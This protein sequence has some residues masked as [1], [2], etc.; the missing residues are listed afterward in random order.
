[1]N[2]SLISII[3]PIYKVED[4][5]TRCV[6]SILEQ[7]YPHMEIILV[8]DGSP[9][10]CGEICDAYAKQDKR[11]S[12][13][14]QEN[15]GLSMARNNGLEKASGDYIS[16]IDSDDWIEP[17]MYETMLEYMMEH[18]LELSECIWKRKNE[19]LVKEEFDKIYIETRDE[20]LQRM[21]VPGFYNVG[22][23]IYKR[24]LIG[25]TR[26]RK[27]VLYEDGL[28]NS[29]IYKKVTQVGFI[30]RNFFNYFQENESIIRSGYSLKKL[31]GIDVTKEKVENFT[32]MTKNKEI[33]RKFRKYFLRRLFN[34]YHNILRNPHFDPDNHHLKKVKKLIW[35]NSK[36]EFNTLYITLINILPIWCYKIFFR[37][38]EKRI[39]TKM[40]ADN[41]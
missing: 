37:F 39:K 15:M 38:N 16:F 19:V 40:A 22:N 34:H 25:D 4:Y 2:K 30:P 27:G 29:E 8:N 5:L 13:V 26:F 3:I 1:M 7:K 36:L 28:F 24:S 23:K 33:H 31:E 6:D 18:G 11:I 12:V 32:G 9:D 10:N 20:A 41:S 14:H 35:A 17:G 21:I